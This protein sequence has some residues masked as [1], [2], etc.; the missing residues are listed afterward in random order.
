MEIVNS[1][2]SNNKADSGGGVYKNSTL[3]LINNTFNEN[4]ADSGGAL[5]NAG[6]TTTVR[7]NIFANSLDEAGAS[8]SLNCDGPTLPSEGRNIVSDNS[9]VPNPSVVGD[10]L[11]TDP[12]LGIWQNNG[13]PT[14]SY[15]PLSNSP[16]I[17]YGLNCPVV[18]QRGLPRPLGSA[19]DVGSIEYGG[20]LYLPVISK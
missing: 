1:T 7:N 11:A 16:T 13:G 4:L 20:I 14:R 9:C 18:D 8:L 12:L 5:Y 2:F 17:D 6:G 10:L 19:C 15:E 3:T